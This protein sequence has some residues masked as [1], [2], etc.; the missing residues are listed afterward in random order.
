MVTVFKLTA[1]L[2]VTLAVCAHGLFAEA[3]TQAPAK[4]PED[5]RELAEVKA[6]LE[7]KRSG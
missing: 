1:R 6:R 3:Q 5:C 2:A 4:A 7:A